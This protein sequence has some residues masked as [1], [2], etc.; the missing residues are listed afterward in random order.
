MNVKGEIKIARE[1]TRVGPSRN[2]Q[3]VT[4]LFPMRVYRAIFPPIR[5]NES[6]HGNVVCI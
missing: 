3:F 6:R 5:P 4:S 1:R 2:D